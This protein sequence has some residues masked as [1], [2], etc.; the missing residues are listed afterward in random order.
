[1]QD[2]L[3]LYYFQS[4]KVFELDGKSFLPSQ[5]TWGG[6]NASTSATLPMVPVIFRAGVSPVTL[7]MF[8]HNY[9]EY[10]DVMETPNEAGGK[11]S[12]DKVNLDMLLEK[13][14]L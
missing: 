8:Y 6:H 7:E 1:M 5:N 14:L 4:E 13:D 10:C 2:G 11:D 3:V 9:D 12:A